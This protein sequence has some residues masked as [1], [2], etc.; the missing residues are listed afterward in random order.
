MKP[1]QVV[2]IGVNHTFKVI[3]TRLEYIPT[4]A[5]RPHFLGLDFILLGIHSICF[6][7]LLL[8]LINSVNY[9]NYSNIEFLINKVLDVK[10]LVSLLIK[11][12]H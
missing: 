2:S 8:T 5:K 11:I 9:I 3:F 4:M 12:C 6:N 1:N 7:A 10:P